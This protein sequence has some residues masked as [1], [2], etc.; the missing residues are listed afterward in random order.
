MRNG[1]RR[2]LLVERRNNW[3]DSVFDRVGVEWRFLKSL[4]CYSE[5]KLLATIESANQSVSDDRDQ[6][7]DD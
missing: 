3:Y 2:K 4:K 1:K 6:L 7:L 5:R